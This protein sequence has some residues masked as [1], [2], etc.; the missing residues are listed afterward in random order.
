MGTQGVRT[1]VVVMFACMWLLLLEV[2]ADDAGAALLAACP[3]T[4]VPAGESPGHALLAVALVVLVRATPSAAA[5][6]AVVLPAVVLAPCPL[7]GALLA[8]ALVVLV[9]ATPSAFQIF[10]KLSNLLGFPRSFPSAEHG[11]HGRRRQGREDGDAV[12]GPP[13]ASRCVLFAQVRW[14]RRNRVGTRRS[15]GA[16]G[17]GRAWKVPNAPSDPLP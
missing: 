10:S 14:S 8:V 9:R 4:I 11:R 15:R 6:P 1:R 2:P 13:G 12:W 3:D 7:A 5:F 16:C 17:R